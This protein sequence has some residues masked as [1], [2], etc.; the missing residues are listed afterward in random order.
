M[1]VYYLTTS[2]ACQD[3]VVAFSEDM[4]RLV[5]SPCSHSTPSSKSA[6]FAINWPSTL[7][8]KREHNYDGK[9]KKNKQFII[10]LKN[11]KLGLS[12]LEN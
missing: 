7:G 11:K 9:I 6:I 10:Y 5:I 12:N 1:K 2:G 8:R 3:D 4:C